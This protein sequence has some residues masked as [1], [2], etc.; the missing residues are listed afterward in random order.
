M[1]CGARHRTLSVLGRDRG[2]LKVDVGKG[3]DKR[4]RK[5]CTEEGSGSPVRTQAHL[6]IWILLHKT[7]EGG[8]KWGGNLALSAR[9]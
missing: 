2:E 4:E 7:K 8:E 9:A 3:R 1:R 6:N 5:C